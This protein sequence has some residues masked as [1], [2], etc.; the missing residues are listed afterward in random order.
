MWFTLPV[1]PSGLD[2]D[3]QYVL[4]SAQANGV[5]FAGVNIMT[6]DYG[7]ADAPNPQGHMGTY[8]IQAANSLFTQLRLVVSPTLTDPQVWNLV[9]VTPMIG[10]NDVSTEV[11][12]QAA[13]QQLL[14]FAQNNGIGLIAMWSINRD[15]QNN[16][17]VV[18][19]V[20]D[21]SSSILQTPNQFSLLFQVFTS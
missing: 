10:L 4:Q 18:H 2:S 1:L 20:D 8:A 9:G 5:S 16:A 15:R 3:G 6:M 19:F 7:D 14:T 21:T 12:D 11:F 13:A 17:G